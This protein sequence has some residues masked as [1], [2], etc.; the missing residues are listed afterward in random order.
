[1]KA[2]GFDVLFKQT[3]PAND[4]GIASGQAAIAARRLQRG[5]I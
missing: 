3:M 2:K 4:G 1:L 5:L